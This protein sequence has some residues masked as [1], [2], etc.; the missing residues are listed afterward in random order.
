MSEGKFYRIVY[1]VEPKFVQGEGRKPGEYHFEEIVD[2]KEPTKEELLK[3]IERLYA[4]S[5]ELLMNQRTYKVSL[6]VSEV[7][8]AFTKDIDKSNIT[9]EAIRWHQDPRQ[10]KRPYEEIKRT[11]ESVFSDGRTIAEVIKGS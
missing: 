11:Q 6:E 2:Y 8:G 10:W 5:K 7:L 3:Y 9:S 1:D 4:A